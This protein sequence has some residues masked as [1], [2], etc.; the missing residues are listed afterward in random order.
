MADALYWGNRIMVI[1]VD[2]RPVNPSAANHAASFAP[3]PKDEP[4][5]EQVA[6]APDSHSAPSRKTMHAEHAAQ[7]LAATK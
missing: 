3:Y 2:C 6:G 5:E 4:S 7:P 1:A